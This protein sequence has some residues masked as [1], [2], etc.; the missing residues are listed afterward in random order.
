M[1]H[2]P[3]RN[4]SQILHCE[5]GARL[6]TLTLSCSPNQWTGFYTIRTSVVKEL[7]RYTRE[8][9]NTFQPIVAFHIETSFNL[10]CKSNDWFLYEMQHYTEK[11]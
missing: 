10:H 6:V 9:V 2:L 8:N 1:S 5:Y 3:K 4:I 11:G 7:I